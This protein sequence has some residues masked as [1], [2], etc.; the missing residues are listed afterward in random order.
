M[1]ASESVS[2]LYG[3]LLKLGETNSHVQLARTHGPRFL[4]TA[5]RVIRPHPSSNP[6]RPRLRHSCEGIPKLTIEPCLIPS[7][8]PPATP[9]L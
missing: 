3:G 1:G 2:V 7:G 5:C 8:N 4:E 9:V 6:P